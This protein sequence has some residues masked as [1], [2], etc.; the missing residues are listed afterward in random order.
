LKDQRRFK[1]HPKAR[2]C[3][4]LC[5]DYERKAYLLM[6]VNTRSVITSRDVRFPRMGATLL[7][8]APVSPLSSEG[9]HSNAREENNMFDGRLSNLSDNARND[10]NDTA[11]AELVVEPPDEIVERPTTP[12]I[13]ISDESW[14]QLLENSTSSSSMFPRFC[15]SDSDNDN[16]AV[17]GTIHSENSEKNGSSDV[18]PLPDNLDHS[19]ELPLPDIVGSSLTTQESG[20]APSGCDL[21]VPIG[22]DLNDVPVG[23]SAMESLVAEPSSVSESS[24]S[25]SGG[26][27]R[28]LVNSRYFNNE[29][30]NSVSLPD[31]PKTYQQAMKSPQKDEWSVAIKKELDSLHDQGTWKFVPRLNDMVVVRSKWVFKLKLNEDGKLDRYKAR[32]VAVGFTQTYL[33]DFD[34]TFSPV[35]NAIT[36]RLLFSLTSHPDFISIQADVET[37]FLQSELDYKIFLEPP[38]GLHAPQGFVLEL[39]RA[40]Y[41]LRQSPL[42]WYLT[43]SKFIMSMGF[44]RCVTDVCLFT[45]SNEMGNIFLSIY[46][47]DLIL[48]SKSQPLIDWVLTHLRGRFP[49]RDVKKLSWTVGIRVCSDL[50]G[51]GFYMSQSSYITSL[52]NR[53]L[54]DESR[55]KSFIPME[56]DF[57]KSECDTEQLTTR[58]DVK[59]YQALIGSLN[60]LSHASRPDIMYSVNA[61]SRFLQSPRVGHW[62]AALRVVKYLNHTPHLSIE[63]RTTEDLVVTLVAFSDASFAALPLID[64]KSVSGILIYVNSNLVFWKSVRQSVVTL[65]AMEAELQAIAQTLVEMQFICNL[66]QEL[67]YKVP[68]MVIYTDSEP[69]IKY[70]YSQSDVL[71]ARTRHIALRYHFIRK[72]IQDDVLELKYVTSKKQLADILTKPL[73][74]PQF[75]YLREQIL[76]SS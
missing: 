36:R 34:E 16:V 17:P 45:L 11:L 26:G 30:V 33:V 24:N 2:Q 14:N 56:V 22:C 55:L 64:G 5:E 53:F 63:F 12:P 57:G 25:S 67:H 66:L 38:P 27:R 69:S 54:P 3:I 76:Q 72:A 60:Y 19:N 21:N 37:A 59:Q 20:D 10:S 7:L 44:V 75:T 8:P 39:L 31:T 74:R 1:Y 65:S 43:L 4:F 40:I 28:K 71:K 18:L 50:Y 6:D 49:I 51:N 46:V 9:I 23:L 47:D 62:K 42:L 68:K 13:H 70:L 15:D 35:L 48:S 52:V 73:A 41:G 29:F 32:V 58:A 61:L